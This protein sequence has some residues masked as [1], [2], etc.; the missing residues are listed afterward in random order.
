MHFWELLILIGDVIVMWEFHVGSDS[1]GM[2]YYSVY[3][4]KLNLSDLICGSQFSFV[5][6]AMIIAFSVNQSCVFC[7]PFCGHDL[8]LFMVFPRLLHSSIAQNCFKQSLRGPASIQLALWSHFHW[9]LLPN[10]LKLH[11]LLLEV[12]WTLPAEITEAHKLWDPQVSPSV[13]ADKLVGSHQYSLKK[14]K[15]P[16]VHV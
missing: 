6:K 3:A 12:Q 15:I 4:L 10:L 5:G 8:N 16:H 13:G 14:K 2:S 1:V 9:N 7:F 11:T